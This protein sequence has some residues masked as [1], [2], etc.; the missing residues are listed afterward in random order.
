MIILEMD[1]IIWYGIRESRKP[2]QSGTCIQDERI[3]RA[4]TF[5]SRKQL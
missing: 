5:L 2:G 1:E 3:D 4:R